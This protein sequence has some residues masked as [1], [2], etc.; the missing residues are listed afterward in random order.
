MRAFFALLLIPSMSWAHG[1]YAH[2]AAEAVETAVQNFESTQA[3]SVQREF[4]EI[5]ARRLGHEQFL[6]SI[7]LNSGST[8]TYACVENETVS[9]VKWEC[10]A[11]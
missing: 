11:N 4:L 3:V 6:V 9:P 2:Q 1:T 7:K 5:S 8:L 10:Q